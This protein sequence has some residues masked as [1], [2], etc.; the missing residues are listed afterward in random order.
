M[1]ATRTLTGARWS[2]AVRCPVKAQHEALGTPRD[3][4]QPPWMDNA[5]ARGFHIGDAW[6]M[7]RAA[8]MPNA[9]RE[10]EVPWG[11]PEWEW[12][13]HADLADMDERII[14]EAFHSKTHEFRPEKALQAAGYAHSLGPDWRAAL[15]T[16]NATDVEADGG[17]A[18]K[19]YPVNVD[20]LREQVVEI[21]ARVVTAV[22]LGEWNPADRISDTPKH[23]E[24]A[25]CPFMSVCHAGWTPPAPEDIVG[26]ETSFDALRIVQSDLH[27]AEAKVAELKRMRDEYRDE[28]REYLPVGV[29]VVSGGTLIKRS[30]VAGRVSVK[31]GDFTKAG[32][33]VPED[34]RPFV[35]EGKPSERWKVDAV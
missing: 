32:F 16:I 10:L 34:L 28:V 35:S 11:P 19:A 29:P 13:G 17:F 33:S 15:V 20:G 14:Y 3:E 12:R 21:Q 8:R 4:N 30:E 9:E 25:A 5:F 22:A 6:A 23:P 31:L 1:S 27:H 26:L 24:C 2:S 18:T 7:I